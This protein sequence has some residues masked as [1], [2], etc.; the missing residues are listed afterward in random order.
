MHSPWRQRRL[1][2]RGSD[3]APPASSLPACPHV[4]DTLPKLP[5]PRSRTAYHCAFV[6]IQSI[7]GRKEKKANRPPNYRCC[8]A[9]APCSGGV[10]LQRANVSPALCGRRWRLGARRGGPARTTAPA[11][12]AAASMCHG[13]CHGS[14]RCGCEGARGAGHGRALLQHLKRPSQAVN[15]VASRARALPPGHKH[16]QATGQEKGLLV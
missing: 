7:G 4:L 13:L 8:L 15:A 16:S 9:G 2:R 6:T 1:M 5:L 12:Q 10:G 11:P 14:C 3:C